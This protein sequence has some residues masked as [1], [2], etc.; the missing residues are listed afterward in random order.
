V[1]PTS[2]AVNVPEPEKKIPQKLKPNVSAR[3]EVDTREAKV[4]MQGP[5]VLYFISSCYSREQVKQV[6]AF[7]LPN[8]RS[9]KTQKI[10]QPRSLHPRGQAHLVQ[11]FARSVELISS[12]GRSELSV[13]RS[14]DAEI[15]PAYCDLCT[16]A[17]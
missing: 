5:S 7:G 4:K 15:A 13:D 16:V 1:C 6:E 8:H 9:L 17:S 2:V 10:R 14:T 12:D 11:F 3:A